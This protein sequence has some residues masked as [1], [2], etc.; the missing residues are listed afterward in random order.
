MGA[1]IERSVVGIRSRIGAGARLKASL[2]LGADFY[3]SLEEIEQAGA[4]GLPPVGVGEGS[5]IEKAILDRD[6]RIG[7]DVRI[8]NEA[9]VENADGK[10][11]YIRDGIVLVPKAGVIPDGTVI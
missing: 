7:R 5:V 4:R 9:K 1:E 2:M 8:V 10:G 3:E 11:W 6:C